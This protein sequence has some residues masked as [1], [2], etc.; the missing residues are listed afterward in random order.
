VTCLYKRLADGVPVAVEFEAERECRG[1]R[2]LVLATY[3]NEM[4]RE[5]GAGRSLT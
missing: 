5:R 1:M 3:K 4:G 2:L